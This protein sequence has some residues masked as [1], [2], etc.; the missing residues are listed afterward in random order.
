MFK[1][2]LN[3]NKLKHISSEMEILWDNK[4]NFVNLF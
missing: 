2:V 1:Q 4:F 3:Q